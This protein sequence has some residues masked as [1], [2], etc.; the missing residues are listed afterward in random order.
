MARVKNDFDLELDYLAKKPTKVLYDVG[1]QPRVLE[2]TLRIFVE[3]KASVLVWRPL[4]REQPKRGDVLPILRGQF[5]WSEFCMPPRQDRVWRGL[6]L[7][8]YGHC[9][10]KLSLAVDEIDGVMRR[11]CAGA[12]QTGR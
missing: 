3:H 4:I 1:P 12:A 2:E 11:S 8:V 5:G 9:S 10:V 6:A 7:G